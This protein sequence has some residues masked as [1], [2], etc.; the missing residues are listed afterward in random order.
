MRPALSAGRSP[1]AV[2]DY[3]GFSKPTPNLAKSSQARTSPS[4]ENQR[5]KL[6]FPSIFFADLGFFNG[7][8]RPLRQKDF[9]LL[10]NRC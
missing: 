5:K 8:R 10:L 2:R 1:R 4:K 6:G 9:F 3:V 7:L